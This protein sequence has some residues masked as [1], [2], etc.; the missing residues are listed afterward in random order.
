[1][2]IPEL[3]RDFFHREY[4]FRDLARVDVLADAIRPSDGQRLGE[5]L[6]TFE[7]IPEETDPGRRRR[8]VRGADR[9]P[10]PDDD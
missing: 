5:F 9:H 3:I 7:P 2:W 1:M 6:T 8:V 4:E 10:G